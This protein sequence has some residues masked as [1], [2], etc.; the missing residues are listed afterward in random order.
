MTHTDRIAWLDVAKATAIVLIVL[1][2]TT[3][4]FLRDVAPGLNIAG[5]APWAVLS[6]A[7]IPVRIPL[8]FLVS[9][10][11]AAR[12]VERPWRRLAGTRFLDLLWPFAIWTALVAPVWM[13]RSDPADPMALAGTAGAGLVLGGLHYWYLPALVVCLVVARLVRRHPVAAVVVSGVV[14][15]GLRSLI[16]PQ[17]AVLGL[18]VLAANLDRWMAFGFWFLLGCFA[19]TFVLGFA[20][21]H[22][23]AGIVA[24]AAFVAVTWWQLGVGVTMLG[25]TLASLTGVAALVLLSSAAS[26]W[27]PVARAG[28]YLAARTLP[29]YLVHAFAFELLAVLAD[30]VDAQ[31]GWRLPLEYGAVTLIVV[32]LVVACAVGLS[33]ALFALSGRA[34]FRWIFEPPAGL[35]DRVL[36]PAAAGPGE[37]TADIEATAGR[38]RRAN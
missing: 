6:T 11:L 24:L 19:R 7:L 32:P 25:T 17:L 13:L 12:A 2:H 36:R 38:R 9:G 34:G 29:I 5:L 20:R 15:F 33:T 21:L 28:R 27:A 4:W 10:V 23:A 8:F 18:P 30:V 3:D 35:R 16:T 26:R 14:A 22:G 31:T 37:A 1:F